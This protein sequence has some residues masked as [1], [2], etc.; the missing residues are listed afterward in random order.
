MPATTSPPTQLAVLGTLWRNET[1][2]HRRPRGRREGAA[3]VDDPHRQRLC[4]K[5]LLVAHAARPATAASSSS[6]LT[7]A[8]DAVLDESRRRKEAWLN[9]RLGELTPAERSMLRDAAP[10]LE[11]LSH[12]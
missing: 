5:G 12:A 9:Q 3:A 10:I 1:M 6:S 2:T 7:E 11:R 8:A 4:D